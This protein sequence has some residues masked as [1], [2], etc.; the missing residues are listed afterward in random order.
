MFKKGEAE[1]CGFESCCGLNNF[2]CYVC[3]A[4]HMGPGALVPLHDKYTLN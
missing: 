4:F 2:H 1:D 3:V